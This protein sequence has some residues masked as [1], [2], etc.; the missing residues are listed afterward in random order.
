[1]DVNEGELGD[2]TSRRC[3]RAIGEE[4]SGTTTAFIRVE[5]GLCRTRL[6]VEEGTIDESRYYSYL[7]MLEGRRQTEGS[8]KRAKRLDQ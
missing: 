2:T 1:M 8:K 4:V 3:G 5:P 7:S 6:P